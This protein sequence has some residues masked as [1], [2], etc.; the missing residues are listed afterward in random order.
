MGRKP[1]K[2]YITDTLIA[3]A[4]I[5]SGELKGVPTERTEF[6]GAITV[7]WGQMTDFLY[8]PEKIAKGSK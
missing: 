5:V 4:K 7:A 6:P 8:R 1:D 3:A 2:G